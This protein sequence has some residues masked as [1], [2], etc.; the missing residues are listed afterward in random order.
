[1]AVPDQSSRINTLNKLGIRLAEQKRYPEA[2]STFRQALDRSPSDPGIRRNL[3]KALWLTGELDAAVVQYEAAADALLGLRSPNGAQRAADVWRDLVRLHHARLDTR[4]AIATR[5]KIVEQL[6]DDL[7]ARADLLVALHYL[8]DVPREALFEEHLAWGRIAGATAQAARQSLAPSPP[9][10]E[11]VEGDENGERDAQNGERD[12]QNIPSTARTGPAA[13]SCSTTASSRHPAGE[14]SERPR[15]RIG[16]FS[17]QFCEYP[18]TRFL[19]HVL[20]GHRAIRGA[21]SKPPS[22]P[23]PTRLSSPK[24]GVPREGEIL[25]PP[26]RIILYSDTRKS[27]AVTRLLAAQC[28]A[29]VDVSKLTDAE[30]ESRLRA[31]DLDL[32][33]DVAGHMDNRRMLVLARLPARR[34]ASYINYPNTTGVAGWDYRLTDAVCDPPGDADALHTESLVRIDPCAW[35]YDPAFGLP[36]PLPDAGPLPATR[37]GAITFGVMARP[38][39]LIPEVIRLWASVLAELP[40]ARL[41]DLTA[42][43]IDPKRLLALFGDAGIPAARITLLPP[44]DRMHYLALHQ[45]VDVLLDTW[46]YNGMTATCDALW[47]GVP[48]VTLAGDRH[49]SRV[50]ASLLRCIGLDDCVAE[51]PQ[52]YVD[53]ARRLVA[54]VSQLAEL[55]NSLRERM[56]LSPVSDGRQIAALIEGLATEGKD[57]SM[58]EG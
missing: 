48:V 27:D 19:A 18:M 6:P 56:R 44:G 32:L 31:D 4:A 35:A 22:Q 23:S 41:A 5:R 39:K 24:S 15:V 42:P 7:A 29:F 58:G 2:I 52:G 9:L 54:D 10:R 33:V 14:Y 49:V 21:S 3:A 26:S 34:L 30:L 16:Y 12:A 36:G 51:T 25:A 38:G 57:S 53:A 40:A 47:M 55:R 11:N 50:G 43:G 45:R 46:P 13:Q 20:A 1:M 8:P 17:G 28:D 37:T